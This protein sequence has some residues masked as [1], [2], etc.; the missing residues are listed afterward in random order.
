MCGNFA[1]TLRS[2][3]YAWAMAK[4]ASERARA[5]AGGGGGGLGT[6]SASVSPLG[7]PARPACLS[8]LLIV[9]RAV[10]RTVERVVK[11]LCNS[12]MRQTRD[13]APRR[14]GGRKK[15]DGG[16]VE[17]EVGDGTGPGW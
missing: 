4:R 5:P 12:K 7:P 15:D 11:L 1:E 6:Y 16:G 2:P 9:G 17:Y 14:S 3:R 13:A 10:G 8:R